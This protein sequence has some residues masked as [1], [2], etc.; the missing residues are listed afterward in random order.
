M[1][2]TLDGLIDAPVYPPAPFVSLNVPATA[3][4]IEGLKGDVRKRARSSLYYFTTAIL[5]WNK[6]RVVPHKGMCDFIQDVTVRRKVMLIPRD[7]YKSTIISKSFPLWV[8]I[9]EEIWG[10]PGLEH[11]ILLLMHAS[12]NAKKQIKSIKNQV[13]RNEMLRWS[14]PELIPDMTVGGWTDNSLTFPR[15]GMYGEATIEHAGIDTHIVSRHYTIQIKDDLEDKASFDSPTVREKV[16]STYRAAESLFV[17]EQ[18][19]V[20]ILVGTRWGSDDLYADIQKNEGDVY[21]FYTRPLHWTRS[22]LEKDYADARDHDRLPVWD[23]DPDTFAPDAEKEYYFFPELFPRAS[24]DRIKKKQGTWMY[25]MLYK[26]NPYDDALH[27]FKEEWLKECW[28]DPDQNVCY[29][30]EEGYVVRVPIESLYRVLFW[31]PALSEEK[32]KKGCNNAMV[33]AGQDRKRN[34]FVLDLFVDKKNPTRLFDK[35]IGLWQRWLIHKAAIE[36]AG[37][38]RILK[39]PLYSHMLEL[40]V[41]FPV[42]DLAPIGQK[43]VRIRALIPHAESNMLFIRKGLNPLLRQELMHFPNWP[44]MDCADA[45]ASTPQMFG[46][47]S[48]AV[49]PQAAQ[50]AARS[51]VLRIASRNATTGY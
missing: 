15:K 47:R 44:T 12:D 26:N 45:L 24:C 5:G 35:F 3:N 9:Q 48:K 20:D 2:E 50:R 36:N 49:D 22:E 11:R 18:S 33:V 37:F 38:Q 43:E 17:E 34:I 39:V 29:N 7:C 14:F 27:E 40:G 19:A 31:D 10:L 28:V 21:K 23:M 46:I 1:D 51:E 32:Q 41:R 42:Q 6:L 30:S 13:E 8:L 25:S 16:K 4:T